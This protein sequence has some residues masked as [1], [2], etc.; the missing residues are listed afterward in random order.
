MAVQATASG[1]T[2]LQNMPVR[3]RSYTTTIAAVKS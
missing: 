2:G 3:L 1:V